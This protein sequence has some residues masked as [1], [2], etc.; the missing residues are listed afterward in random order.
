[1]KRFLIPALILT[2]VNVSAAGRGR[3]VRPP[4]AWTA[5]AC[6][7]TTGLPGFYFTRD[8]GRTLSI[9]PDPIPVNAGVRSVV[10]T[11]VPNRMYAISGDGLYES[12]NAGCSW[13]FRAKI[14]AVLS[15][16]VAAPGGRAY[17]WNYTEPRIVRV[18]AS[19]V[20]VIALP[21]APRTF[22]V[23]PADAQHLMAVTRERVLESYDGGLSWSDRGAI[24]ATTPLDTAAV[25]PRDV[26]HIAVGYVALVGAKASTAV[27]LDGGM[28]WQSGNTQGAILRDLSF[29]P[30]DRN[31][32]WTPGLAGPFGPLRVYRSVDGGLTYTTVPVESNTP[33]PI[34]FNRLTLT[35]SPH[36]RDIAAYGAD[37]GLLIID[38]RSG[39]ARFAA[40]QE[41]NTVTWS[42]APGVIYLTTT[43]YVLTDP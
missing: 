9:N 30:A 18:S 16:L 36:D 7:A 10:I 41:W 39:E 37:S 33:K 14:P 4:A 17:A 8:E 43:Y 34:L 35:P 28:T 31:V 12:A 24:P 38:A 1:M 19:A 29:S 13:S 2:S 25:D 22:G 23:D 26:R 21:D 5:P 27:S 32:I 15:T 6:T 11:D 42:P 40:G 20:E 3:V